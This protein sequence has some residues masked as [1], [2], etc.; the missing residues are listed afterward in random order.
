MPGGSVVR[1][2]VGG[3]VVESGSA[4]RMAGLIVLFTQA[5]GQECLSV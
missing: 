1:L 5:R 4:G 3:L 2:T